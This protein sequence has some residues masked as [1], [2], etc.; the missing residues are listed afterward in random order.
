MDKPLDGEILGPEDKDRESRVK[1]DFWSTLR[2]ASRYVPFADEIVASYY[3]AM[4]PQTPTRVRVILLG[5]L[6][7]FV[8]P[9]D[10]I[11]DFLLMFGFVDDVTILTAAIASV[12]GNITDAH[13]L[14]AKEALKEPP[15][16]SV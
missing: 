11:P 13:R 5:A 12:R 1:R 2:K 3:C 7:Y 15:T 10:A 9:V 8:L 16:S 6:A 14:A 4:D